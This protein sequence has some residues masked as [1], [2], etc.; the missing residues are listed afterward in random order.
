M[1]SVARS[2]LV[3]LLGLGL[4]A[5]TLLSYLPKGSGDSKDEDETPLSIPTGRPPKSIARRM[6]R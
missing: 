5:C 6:R 1:R 3:L 2:V 4:S